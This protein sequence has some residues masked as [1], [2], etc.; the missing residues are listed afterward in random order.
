MPDWRRAHV[1]GGTY[2]FTVVTYHRMRFLTTAM[3]RQIL[4][5]AIRRCRQ[6]WPM[7]IPAMVLLPDHLH[8]IWSLPL[9]DEEYSKRWAWIKKEFTKQ[10][11]AE[12]GCEART[13]EGRKRDGRRAVWQSKFWEHTI[14]DEDDFEKHFDYIHFNPVKHGLVECPI[15]WEWSSFHR[16]VR[17][18]VYPANWACGDRENV[19]KFQSIEKTVGE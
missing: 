8:T 7:T 4:G 13:T 9:G 11:L 10:W 5:D 2:F 17:S 12:G 16:H 14:R 18:G 1:P 6:R 3:A 15:D 19:P